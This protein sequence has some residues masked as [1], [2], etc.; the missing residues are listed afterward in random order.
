MSADSHIL[1]TDAAATARAVVVLR[2]VG[3]RLALARIAG[4][5]RAGRAGAGAIL[6]LGRTG[7]CGNRRKLSYF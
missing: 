3:N 7:S 6:G 5:V 4:R 1:Y 2:P